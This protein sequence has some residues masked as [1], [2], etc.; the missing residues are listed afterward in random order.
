M[1]FECPTCKNN[2]SDIL[3]HIRKK[4][5]TDTYTTL[6]LQPIGLTPCPTCAIACKGAHG[7]KTHSAKIHGIT[8]NSKISTQHRIHTAPPASASSTPLDPEIDDST[9]ALYPEIAFPQLLP[10]F[11]ASALTARA[12][13]G[14]SEHQYPNPPALTYAQIIATSPISSAPSV[15]LGSKPPTPPSPTG[16][17][18]PKATTPTGLQ[19]PIASAYT[20]RAATYAQALTSGP[21]PPVIQQTTPTWKPT[22]GKR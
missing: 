16:L 6:Q 4:H 8:G 18:Q 19:H 20:P 21:L 5:P 10:P 1:A 17:Y 14:L 9:G 3:D 7:V 15:P 12:P 22:A 13:L 11:R 2:Y